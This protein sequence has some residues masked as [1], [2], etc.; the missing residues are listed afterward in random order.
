[1]LLVGLLLASLPL[2]AE[3]IASKPMPKPAATPRGFV[4]VPLPEARAYVLK[5]R[6]WVT[7]RQHD[8]RLLR[9]Q[10]SQ[11]PGDSRALKGGN[12]RVLVTPG[13]AT[14][15][16]ARQRVLTAD[17]EHAGRDYR[18]VSNSV[19]EGKRIITRS[20]LYV[21]RR[22]RKRQRIAMRVLLGNKV[23]NTVYDLRF[24]TPKIEWP[25]LWPSGKKMVGYFQFDLKY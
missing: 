11:Y 21:D 16:D 8:G 9:W 23:T 13:S 1:M 24:M 4:W 2:Q 12:L 5:P 10:I 7:S 6:R 17:K 25:R 14:R 19:R 18:I 15:P 20:I 3:K 22:D